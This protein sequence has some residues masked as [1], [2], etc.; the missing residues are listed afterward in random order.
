MNEEVKKELIDHKRHGDKILT[1]FGGIF[2]GL[3]TIMFASIFNLYQK[4]AERYEKLTPM[5]TQI[6]KVLVRT[7]VLNDIRDDQ[8]E[9]RGDLRRIVDVVNAERQ[10]MT[11]IGNLVT[12]NQKQIN[13]L[14]E[15]LRNV[16]LY[17]LSEQ[18]L[19]IVKERINR[20]LNQEKAR[21]KENEQK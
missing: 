6:E 3:M 8:K 11:L 5:K 4:E 15:V 16:D 10:K 14:S 17:Y 2:S 18:E 1:I 21:Q 12:E 7:E 19:R 20:T 9:L 13:R